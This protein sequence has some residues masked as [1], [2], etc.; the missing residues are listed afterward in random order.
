MEEEYVNEEKERFPIQIEDK[1]VCELIRK[2][3]ALEWIAQH[4]MNKY[5]AA[6]LDVWAIL[7]NIYSLDMKNHVYTLASEIPTI[8]YVRPA[9]TRR[10]ETP[11]NQPQLL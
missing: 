7:E 6:M 11:P 1:E 3:R 2:A 8:Y 9:E 10:Y 4:H 5:S